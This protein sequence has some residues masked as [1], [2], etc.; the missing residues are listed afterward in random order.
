MAVSYS[1]RQQLS[2]RDRIHP[3][4]HSSQK[5]QGS[6]FLVSCLLGFCSDE[7]I[8]GFGVWV[9]LSKYF[10]ASWTHWCWASVQSSIPLLVLKLWEECFVRENVTYPVSTC[11]VHFPKLMTLPQGW[12]RKKVRQR[13]GL[14]K[15]CGPHWPKANPF[16]SLAPGWRGKF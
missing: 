4:H 11:L 9:F 2:L 1:S 8:Q 14:M 7:R 15:R 6:R 13:K 12:R 3:S 16:L 5:R 10:M